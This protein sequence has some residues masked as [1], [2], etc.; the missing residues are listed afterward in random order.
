[1]KAT[2]GTTYNML[3]SRLNDVAQKLEELR[4]IGATG[5]KLNKPSDDPAAIRPVFNTRKQ[6]SNVDR[7]L[8]TMGLSLDTMQSTDGY[9]NSVEN[10]MQRVKE[11]MTTAANG[12][13]NDQDRAVLADE[14]SE[15]R[16]QLLDTSN[17]MVNGKYMF[18]G[19]KVDT[20]PFVENPSYTKIGY[21]AN[22]PN[23]WPVKYQGDGNATSLEITTGQ[24]VQVNLTGSDLFFGTA[25]WDPADPTKQQLDSGRYNLF[26][27]L[28][29]AEEALREPIQATRD[30][31]I[32]TSLTDLEGAADQSRRLRSQLGNR[33]NL[34]Q[35]T[36]ND[37]QGVNTDLKQ[38]LSRYQDADVIEAFNNITQQ[39][40]AF[41]AALSV[42]GQVS[43]LSILDYI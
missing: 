30:A 9:L 19:Y 29:Q 21:V 13:L 8:N 24:Q 6:I 34:V 15:L 14:L 35:T 28:T 1:M 38:I 11:I 40:T 42:T 43:K 37:Q 4:N 26:T 39:E 41:Q 23:T 27:E 32:Q 3:G 33:A 10:T 31:A 7:N 22:D 2:Q 20:I 5:K 16:K 18:G 17:G 36:M 25:A 12:S